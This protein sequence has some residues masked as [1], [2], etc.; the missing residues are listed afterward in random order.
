MLWDI[1]KKME[2]YCVS[3]DK[4]T[5]NKSSE[6]ILRNFYCFLSNTI[7]CQ[8]QLRKK[9]EVHLRPRNYFFSQESTFFSQESTS[10]L[11]KEVHFLFF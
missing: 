6:Y 10:S 4:N 2:T 11:K 3:S 8:G 1:L 7:N 5:A 9:K